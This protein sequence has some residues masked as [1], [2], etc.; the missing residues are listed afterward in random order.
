MLIPSKLSRPVRLQNTVIRARLIARLAAVQH[1]RLALIIRPAGYGKTTP[2]AQWGADKA[3]IDWYS[4]DEANNYPEQFATYLLAAIQH[5]T[6][7]H[8]ERSDAMAQKRQ[9]ASLSALFSPL[10]ID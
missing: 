4:L 8:C 1:Y 10:V 2:I 6:A 3:D 7:N 9:Y 5:A